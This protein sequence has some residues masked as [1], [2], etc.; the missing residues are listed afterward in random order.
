M[1][2]SDLHD[3]IAALPDPVAV[4]VLGLFVDYTANLPDPAEHR[5]IEARLREAAQG[6]PSDGPST[7]AGDLSRATLAYLAETPTHA[8]IVSRAIT[9]PADSTRFDPAVLGIGAVV[10]VALQTEVELT[11]SEE[12]KWRLKIHKRAMSDSSFGKLVT[13]LLDLYRQ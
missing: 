12:G 9:M 8:E 4:R 13:K 10:L 11:R 7:S 1:S 6:T 3:T 2:S 5:E